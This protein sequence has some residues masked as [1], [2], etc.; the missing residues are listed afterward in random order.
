MRLPRGAAA[1]RVGCRRRPLR[2][3]VAR[4]SLRCRPPRSLRPPHLLQRR[5]PVRPARLP[6]RRSEA[7]ESRRPRFRV[8][9]RPVGRI[10]GGPEGFEE[11]PV[12]TLGIEPIGVVTLGGRVDAER[13]QIR[14][15]I[16]H[17]TAGELRIAASL[18]LIGL[19]GLLVFA[20]EVVIGPREVPYKSGRWAVDRL[21]SQL[22]RDAGSTRRLRR[23]RRLRRSAL[24]RRRWS[25]RRPDR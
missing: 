7:P 4:R 18:L 5:R 25:R 17:H 23:L 21:P 8:R 19:I 22:K 13:D 16:G 10:S 24:P 1:D 6:S 9:R 14:Q 11:R 20:P 15:R 3:R 12:G 2:V